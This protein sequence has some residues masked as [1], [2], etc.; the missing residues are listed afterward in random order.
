LVI[1]KI[2]FAN[3]RVKTFRKALIHHQGMAHG[4][5]CLLHYFVRMPRGDTA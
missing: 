1:K 4:E 3:T 2:P 5:S